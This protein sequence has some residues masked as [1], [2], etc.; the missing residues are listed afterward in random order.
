MHTMKTMRCLPAAAAL[1]LLAACQ[2]QNAQPTASNTNP[3]EVRFT[4]DAYQ[5]IQFDR[6]EGALALTQAKDPE[7]I[8][9]AAQLTNQANQFATQLAPVAMGAGITPPRVLREDLR[10]R[11]GHMQLQQGLD[12]DRN[13]I[14]DQIASHEEILKMENGM[15]NEGASP[16]FRKLMQQGTS[17]LQTN[18]DK[19]R[20]VQARIGP[21]PKT[22]A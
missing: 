22:S 13:Y 3:A 12:F 14:A 18:L 6:Q 8:A 2:G 20:A 17:L 9:L 4:T 1:L 10:V 11:L 21:P 16:Q 7:V 5:I 15:G 19:L